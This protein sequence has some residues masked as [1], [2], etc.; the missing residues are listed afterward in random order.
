MR[1][2][3]LATLR[4]RCE[5]HVDAKKFRCHL[6][7][8]AHM[9]NDDMKS[10][11]SKLVK[12]Q[13]SRTSEPFDLDGNTTSSLPADAAEYVETGVNW[14]SAF[15]RFTRPHTIIGSVSAH[16]HFLTVMLFYVFSCIQRCSNLVPDRD[17]VSLQCR[18]WPLNL[19]VILISSSSSDFLRYF[20]WLPSS[21]QDLSL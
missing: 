11:R 5:N 1:S 14:L 12:M 3:G 10:N 8:S 17:W 4:Q 21:V 7:A 16:L 15:W 2:H 13:T 20:L 9:N 6:A 19:P 18:F